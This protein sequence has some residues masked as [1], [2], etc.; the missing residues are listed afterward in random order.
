MQSK[1][2]TPCSVDGCERLRYARGL[3]QMHFVQAQRGK[4]EFPLPGR[5]P[6]T[7]TA[8]ERFWAKV[9]K[10][11]ACWLWTGAKS[12]TGYGYFGANTRLAHRFAYEILVGPIPEGYEVDHLCRVRNCVNPAHLEAVTKAVNSA[13]QIHHGPP[14][15]DFCLRGHPYDEANT[16]A[17]S[18]G[19]RQ[20]RICHREA[21]RRHHARQSIP[22][23]HS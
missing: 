9:E 12:P 22:S 8:E 23:R 11:D 7:A 16:Y 17:P 2:T 3:C 13:R 10:T 21:V 1:S 5:L 14:K 15:K 4:R 20:C 18:R 6:R 19:S